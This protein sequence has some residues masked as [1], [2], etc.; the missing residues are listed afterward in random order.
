MSDKL[1]KI[2][3]KLPEELRP[4]AIQYAS[5]FISM[6][7]EEIMQWIELIA[8]GNLSAAYE[9]VVEKM[10]NEDLI[11]EWAVIKDKWDIANVNNAA[12]LELQ[13]TAITAMLRILL[14]IAIAAVGL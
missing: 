4:W 9:R 13:R 6:T 5:I 8:A 12:K 2:I 11:N 7:T 3:N 10:E 14:T 1:Q